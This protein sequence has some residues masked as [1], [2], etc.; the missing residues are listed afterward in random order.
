MRLIGLTG[1]I[2]SG[3][4]T[5]TKYLLK[6]GFV[7]IDCDKITADLYKNNEEFIGGLV[8]L[9]GGSIMEKGKVSKKKV[10]SIVFNN[11]DELQ[12]LNSYA[13]P[14]LISEIL[15]QIDFNSSEEV[16]F[17]D[18]PVLFEYGLHEVLSFTDIW[19]VS[20]SRT[21]Q[22]ERLKK[23]NPD[24]SEKDILDRLNKQWSDETK[25]ALSTYIITNKG[26]I[27]DL[28]R[29]VDMGISSLRTDL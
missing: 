6:K 13:F 17:I 26:T 24:L 29:K 2:A 1:G 9:F 10:A 23:R 25:C 14:F 22:I 27:A 3:K 8:S 4:S 28:Y 7:V 12:K 19:V 20:V 5:V 21:V 18:A 15:Y 16:V 11:A